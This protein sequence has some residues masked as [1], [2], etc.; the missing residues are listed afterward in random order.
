MTFLTLTET[1]G[2]QGRDQVLGP[3][4][5]KSRFADA[6]SVGGLRTVLQLLIL[7]VTPEVYTHLE[8]TFDSALMFLDVDKRGNM[9]ERHDDIGPDTDNELAMHFLLRQVFQDVQGILVSMIALRGTIP[10]TD[11]DFANDPRYG[12]ADNQRQHQFR[13]DRWRLMLARAISHL[14]LYGQAESWTQAEVM[15]QISAFITEFNRI[16]APTLGAP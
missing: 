10:I 9:A 1:I 11:T 5:Y 2:P 4:V 8:E 13:A 16:I 14:K 15:Q 12:H 3:L 6:D 7:N